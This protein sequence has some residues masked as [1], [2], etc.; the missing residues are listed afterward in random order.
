MSGFGSEI[1]K[2]G[3]SLKCSP[4]MVMLFREYSRVRYSI[5]FYSHKMVLLFPVHYVGKYLELLV[6]SIHREVY[7]PRESP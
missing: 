6:G 2:E 3:G 4:F 7:V 5:S 1:A